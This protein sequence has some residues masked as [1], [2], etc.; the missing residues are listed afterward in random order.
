MLSRHNLFVILLSRSI[1]QL[2]FVL[3]FYVMSFWCIAL[4]YMENF[5]FDVGW[6]RQKP[7]NCIS[8]IFRRSHRRCSV[9][10]GVLKNFTKSIGKHLCQSLFL[11]KVAELRP[12]TLLKKRLWHMWIPV[13]FAKCSRTPFLQNTSGRLLLEVI[14]RHCKKC[15]KVFRQGFL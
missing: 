15:V 8:L 4:S 11:N 13:S 9:K 14:D 10:K 2:C 6:T 1:V 5:S 3:S 12:A 7:T